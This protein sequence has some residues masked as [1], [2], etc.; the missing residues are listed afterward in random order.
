MQLGSSWRVQCRWP[1]SPVPAPDRMTRDE[2]GGKK[3][4]G[5]EEGRQ[6][7]VQQKC[8]STEAIWCPFS[9]QVDVQRS[10]L[11]CPVH[12]IHCPHHTREPPAPRQHTSLLQHSYTQLTIQTPYTE[13]AGTS[14]YCA[15]H[16]R[17]CWQVAQGTPAI[18]Q[19][20]IGTNSWSPVIQYTNSTQ[21]CMRSQTASSFYFSIIVQTQYHC[22]LAL[23]HNWNYQRVLP[24]IE[25]RWRSACRTVRQRSLPGNHRNSRLYK[26]Y[27]F[28]LST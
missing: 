7:K 12:Y 2:G 14:W 15:G 4:G 22:S 6:D 20:G 9:C 17:R 10:L 13:C 23:S 18:W 27:Q 19:W 16:S 5:G 28:I 26:L 25:G 21:R 11:C 8:A 24:G 1:P 3:V